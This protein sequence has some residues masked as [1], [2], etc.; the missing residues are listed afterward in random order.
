MLLAPDEEGGGTALMAWFKRWR[1][2]G[3]ERGA[4]A[5]IEL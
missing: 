4:A 5:L 3:A 1:E 2:E